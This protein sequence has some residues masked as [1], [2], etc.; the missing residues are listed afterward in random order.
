M[1]VC[2]PENQDK[3][4]VEILG[5]K[6]IKDCLGECSPVFKSEVV[7]CEAVSS[8]QLFTIACCT[9]STRFS[10]RKIKIRNL[11]FACQ[12]LFHTGVLHLCT[13]FWEPFALRSSLLFSWSGINPIQAQNKGGIFPSFF[14]SF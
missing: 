6:Q 12:G 9:S 14:F 1:K 7:Y 5:N 3:R 8:K 2:G 10:E 4:G 11:L 13:L